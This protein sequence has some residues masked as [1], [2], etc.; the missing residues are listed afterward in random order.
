MILFKIT[1]WRK[2]IKTWTNQPWLHNDFLMVRPS[3]MYMYVSVFKRLVYNS[4][5]KRFM[6]CNQNNSTTGCI[7]KALLTT[8]QRIENTKSQVHM[9]WN[10][11]DKFTLIWIHC[12][13][14]HDI[15]IVLLN[16]ANFYRILNQ[17]LIEK[18]QLN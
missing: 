17:S 11:N 1:V 9:F 12:F 8:N 14:Y 7:V 16:E 5:V 3:I 15:E 10:K 13:N 4:Y 2:C 18:R 6:A